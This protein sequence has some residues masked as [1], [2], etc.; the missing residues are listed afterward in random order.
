MENIQFRK[1]VARQQL[2][3]GTK[4]IVQTVD[5][6]QSETHFNEGL[7]KARE[8]LKTRGIEDIKPIL[9]GLPTEDYHE[10]E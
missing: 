1:T 4:Q 5:K 7:M 9:P 3:D 6:S 8:F 2:N 10:H